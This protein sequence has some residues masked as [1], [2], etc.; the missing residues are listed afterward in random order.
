MITRKA[1][2]IVAFACVL[3]LATI[4]PGVAASQANNQDGAKPIDNV[5]FV[6]GWLYGM[7]TEG[8]AYNLGNNFSGPSKF[9]VY[10]HAGA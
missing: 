6:N 9:K 8:G 7:T 5:I 10:P 2:F 3:V 4:S 1:K